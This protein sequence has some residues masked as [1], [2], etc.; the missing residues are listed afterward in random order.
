MRQ[1]RPSGIRLLL[2]LLVALAS[3]MTSTALSELTTQATTARTR[4]ISQDAMPSIVH[5]AALRGELFRAQLLTER[6]LRG[7]P[8]AWP[9]VQREFPDLAGDLDEE[10]GSYEKLP[11][12]VGEGALADAL[13][14]QVPRIEKQLEEAAS[15][16]E[17]AARLE[18]LLPTLLRAE[19]TASALIDY[20]ADE[21]ESLSRDIEQ[22]HRRSVLIAW[23]L[24]VASALLSLLVA[25]LAWRAVRYYLDTQEAQRALLGARAEELEAFSGRVAHDILNPLN[26]VQLSLALMERGVEPE[27]VIPRA[28]N[29]VRRVQRIIEALLGFARA[30]ARP[31]PGAHCQVRP[32]LEGVLADAG[33]LAVEKRIELQLEAPAQDAWVACLPGVLASITGNLVA[34]A[35]K[36]LDPG[37]LERRVTVRATPRSG[38]VVFE[39]EDTG[40]GIEPAIQRT[41]FEPYVRGKHRE[42]PGIGLGLATAKKLCEAH[43]GHIGVRSAPGKG[44]TFWFE[45]PEAPPEA[46]A[47]TQQA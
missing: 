19:G 24:D 10:L 27:Q 4:D 31:E 23:T 37:A 28:Q 25:F 30:G 20:N 18:P 8:G 29:S 12:S 17:K 32:V 14:H 2:V 21:G 39:V 45:L 38:S 22:A 26:A 46:P 47:A 15:S 40:P 35:I 41:L 33:E 44:A 6:E 43:G 7:E 1:R 42:Q 34:N 13:E 11:R 9:A 5:L 36:Y 16:S 3:F